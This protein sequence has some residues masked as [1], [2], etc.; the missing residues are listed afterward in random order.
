M[1]KFNDGET[2]TSSW[3]KNNVK[4]SLHFESELKCVTCRRNIQWS[5]GIYFEYFVVVVVQCLR[6]TQNNP[7]KRPVLSQNNQS[8]TL[9]P[10]RSHPMAFDSFDFVLNPFRLKHQKHSE[11]NFA[12]FGL[13][14][15]YLSSIVLYDEA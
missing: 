8:T 4:C 15:R 10:I 12:T 14:F 9:L 1:K 7:P 2:N 6:N 3:M 5:A 11:K 13:Y